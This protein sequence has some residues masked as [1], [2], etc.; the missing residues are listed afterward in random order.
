ML[1]NQKGIPIKDGDLFILYSNPFRFL[2]IAAESLIE[3]A[4]Q[5]ATKNNQQAEVN[6]SIGA[7]VLLLLS[8]EALINRV[9][10]E[11][12]KSKFP[13]L[14]NEEI[15]D[16]WSL[17][18]K[19]YFAPLFFEFRDNATTFEVDKEPWQ[20]FS[21]L[22]KIRDYFAHPKPL[23]Y[24]LTISNAEK[25]LM[26]YTEDDIPRWLQTKI[27]KDL[28]HLRVADA[29][30]VLETIKQMIDKLDSFMGGIIKKD[31]W[32]LTEQIRKDEKSDE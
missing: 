27:P 10:E 11:F 17:T 2:Y 20:S 26:D 16:K 32:Y 21:E 31:D 13:K 24:P 1:N 8:I 3:D 25:K 22:K 12:I 19:W 6:H 5:A 23:S 7:I 28:N 18:I 9:Y 4:K 29:Q 15:K 30:K 14:V